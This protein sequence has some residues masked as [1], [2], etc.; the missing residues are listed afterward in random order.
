MVTCQAILFFKLVNFNVRN[1]LTENFAKNHY[2]ANSLL[3]Q[4]FEKI[5]VCKQTLA[6]VS[7]GLY[8]WQDC[9]AA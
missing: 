1:H 2:T 9:V 3:N 8:V 4:F 7:R 5:Y 6:S